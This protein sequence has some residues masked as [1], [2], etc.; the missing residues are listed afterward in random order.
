M[1]FFA[2]NDPIIQTREIITRGPSLA[3]GFLTE[4]VIARLKPLKGGN[5]IAIIFNSDAIEI[6]SP[7]ID[8]Q[9]ISPIVPIA[10]IDHTLTRIRFAQNIRPRADEGREAAVFKGQT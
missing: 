6:V 8:G 3:A 1:Q 2:N 9:I 10:N 7:A 5:R 4:Q